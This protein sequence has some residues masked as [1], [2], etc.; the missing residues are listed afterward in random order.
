MSSRTIS[1]AIAITKQEKGLDYR[2]IWNR[3]LVGLPRRFWWMITSDRRI[4][5]ADPVNE[6]P[7]ACIF[8][9]IRMYYNYR[10]MYTNDQ[11]YFIAIMS[12]WGWAEVSAGI[13]V[14]CMPTMPRFMRHLRSN[15]YELKSRILPSGRSPDGDNAKIIPRPLNRGPINSLWSKVLTLGSLGTFNFGSMR[16]DSEAATSHTSIAEALEIKIQDIWVAYIT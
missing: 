8:S 2:C 15:V 12:L 1:L 9:T 11:S 10:L 5:C 13:A 4:H 3:S 16:L 14:S 6:G 7:R